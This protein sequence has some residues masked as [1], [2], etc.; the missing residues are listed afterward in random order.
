[1]PRS[2]P[3]FKVLLLALLLTGIALLIAEPRS[4][5]ASGCHAPD[6][7]VLSHSLSWDQWQRI[8]GP[9]SR[10]GA[11]APPVLIP[12]PCQGEIPTLPSQATGILELLPTSEFQAD[13]PSPGECLAMRS[14]AA[15][16]P[17]LGSRLDRPPRQTSTSHS[18]AV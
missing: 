9:E 18:I 14:L 16:I 3:R 12:K 11:P 2:G 17:L 6:R 7:P 4:A 10:V 15:I 13:P 8:G 5:H 1:V